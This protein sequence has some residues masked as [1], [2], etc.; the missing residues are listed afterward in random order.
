MGRFIRFEVRRA[1]A[2]VMA[3][4]LVGLAPPTWADPP[5]APALSAAQKERLKDRDKFEQQARALR[6]EGK[7]A[8]AIQAAE[9]MLAIEREV[10][11]EA[12]EDEIGS[13]MLLAE[14]HQDRGDW[15]AAR[16]ARSKV[17]AMWTEK[18][19][20]S[21][22]QV[23]E[24]RWALAKVEALS[25]LDEQGR[26]RLAEADQLDRTAR[27][28]FAQ[29]RNA[30]AVELLRRV[31]AIRRE[32]LGEN[33]PDHATSLINLGMAL[34]AQG[35]LVEALK[36]YQ[37]GIEILQATYQQG[38]PLL[39]TSLDRL[40]V[41]ESAQGN[42]AEARRNL[43]RALEMNRA[44][45]PKARYPRG[46]PLL[47]R[48][49]KSLGTLLQGQ[50]NYAEARRCLEQA[51][52]MSQALYPKETYPG[53]HPELA[54]CLSRLGSLFGDQRDYG[55]AR[56]YLERALEMR[57]TLHPKQQYPHGHLELA[58]SLNDLGTLLVLQG[59]AGE[60]RRY[61]ERSLE[62]Y[63][64]LYPKQ[65]Y[66][67]GHPKLAA[68]L[69]AL[70]SMLLDQRNYTE[71]RDYLERAYEMRQNLYPREVYPRGHPELA[72]SLSELGRLYVLLAQYGA[73]RKY[74]EREL[75]MRRALYPDGHP[76]LVV[77]LSDLGFVLETQGNY[78]EAREYI[79]RATEMCRIWYPKALYPLGH[80]HLAATLA[81][82]GRVEERQENHREAW[83]L[84]DEAS[85]MMSDLNEVFVAAASE[86]EAL[87]YL[88]Q[89]PEFHDNLL[90]CSYH[91][92]DKV[93]AVY[94][95]VWRHK[96]L[97]ARTLE[98][99]QASFVQ[100]TGSDRAS[101]QI[102]EAWN[103]RRRELARL[104]LA[105]PDGRNQAERLGRLE[106]LTT[107]KERLERRLA[108]ALPEFARDQR[109]KR[110][111]HSELLRALPDRTVVIDLTQYNR[112][113]QD[114]RIKGVRGQRITLSYVGFVLAKGGP[115]QRVELGPAAPVDDAVRQWRQSIVEQT[116]G[117]AALTLRH[118]VWEPLARHVPP[119][120]TTVNVS[121]DGLL[122][123]IPWGA[124]P[125]EQPGTVLL[126]HYAFATVPHAPF[127]L[128]VLTAP[129][130]WTDDRGTLL[131]V[132]GIAQDLPGAAEELDA[133][134][135]LAE[136]KTVVRLPVEKANTA[137]V[138]RELPLARWAHFATHGFFADP[139]THS[140]LQADPNPFNRLRREG[141]APVARNPLVLSGLVLPGAD[142]R[143]AD[144]DASSGD[145]QGIL[146]GEAIAGLPLRNLELA[147]LSACETGLGTVAG[148]EGVFGLQRAFH[149]A[150]ARAVVASLW[151]VRDQATKSMMTEFYKNLW[152]KKLPKLE[153]LRQAQLTLIKDYSRHANGK[154][155]GA[156]DKP[157]Q[158]SATGVVE[159]TPAV[160]WAAFV[161]SGDWR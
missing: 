3:V 46:H 58:S 115:V 16:S 13:H 69:S 5:Q 40:A 154:P 83:R 104:L 134:I 63:Q 102:V 57:E 138:L 38:H 50:G 25:K 23:A 76:S 124:L 61:L 135:R 81:N 125:G 141:L 67:H 114:P 75:E 43:E 94:A 55:E 31:V 72:L 44:F 8:E 29:G 70:G 155:D 60:A 71:A 62:M 78:A 65:E 99:R 130:P 84:L 159:R 131:A 116:P 92:A 51:L 11:G 96:A 79:Q 137:G 119:G 4:A 117:A 17:L 132:G 73:A 112:L 48:S 2:A 6:A 144:I 35:S 45:Y 100:Q 52:E 151:K 21:H 18:L 68:N 59:S 150:G 101:R 30:E 32:L 158:A 111:P 86:A 149:L 118:L 106:R 148:G 49:L 14:L 9:A 136:P 97:I 27:A 98:R 113:E 89:F 160:Y 128:D 19:G 110:S 53:G 95:H 36:C 33:H 107:E 157:A 28:G 80:S 88:A 7:T 156:P 91:L 153:A 20:K 64:S 82:L 108:D 147:V 12:S 140:V 87:D 26:R 66:P 10:L 90:S 126:E 24:A 103:D 47:A 145:A 123:A 41:L 1:A 133:V 122:T 56:R 39:A 109:L 105:P 129:S 42:H 120:T 161:L 142:R 74:L 139:R 121:P 15:A 152:E 22:W 77:V 37:R 146:T 54:D 93:E 85:R 127:V 143:T 34:S